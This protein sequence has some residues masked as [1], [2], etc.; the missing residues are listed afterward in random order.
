MTYRI[1]NPN[2]EVRTGLT[3]EDVSNFKRSLQRRG[4]DPKTSGY[5]LE[6]EPA[7]AP[8]GTSYEERR[9]Y[10]KD[11]SPMLAEMFPN[12]AEQ[13]MM[14]NRD[15]NLGT[16]KAGISDAL[17]YPGRFVMAVGNSKDTND[18]EGFNLGRRAEDAGGTGF[19]K[20]VRN[21]MFAGGMALAPA[22]GASAA[23]GSLVP[24]IAK[25]AAVGAAFGGADASLNGR[26]PG[27]ADYGVGAAI[28]GA[29]EPVAT[30]AAKAAALVRRFGSNLERA[31]ASALR[32]G[33]T[34]RLLTDAEFREFMADP[35][36][37]AVFDETIKAVE[38]WKNVN[39]LVT[40]KG[41]TLTPLKE[42]ARREAA[43]T[44]EGEQSLRQGASE[45]IDKDLPVTER[46]IQ[47]R[48]NVANDNNTEPYTLK[49]IYKPGKHD[50]TDQAYQRDFPEARLFESKPRNTK[51]PYYQSN[52]E[53]NIEK[54]ADKYDNIDNAV[55]SMKVDPAKKEMT[56]QE[57]AIIAD[58]EKELS[59]DNSVLKGYN[60]KTKE[61]DLNTVLSANKFLG[62]RVPF[63][64]DFYD[65]RLLPFIEENNFAGVSQ[66]F[67]D[68]VGSMVG[69]ANF[70]GRDTM[71]NLR[72]A[73]SGKERAV[74]ER[75]FAYA[76]D[77][78]RAVKK[79]TRDAFDKF[80]DTLSDYADDSVA[81]LRTNSSG[82]DYL[83]DS[84]KVKK[85]A[86][87]Y[88]KK[89][90]DAL[91]YNT[92]ISPDTIIGLYGDATLHN[93]KVVQDAV[94][95]LMRDLKVSNDV[96]RK[97][98]TVGRKYTMLKKARIKLDKNA[99]DDSNPFKGTI[100]AP[101]Y[102][103]EGVN[104]GNIVGYKLGRLMDR[105]DASRV[106]V[107]FNLGDIGRLGAYRL[108]MDRK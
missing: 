51:D 31:V 88:L 83:V 86:F 44:L 92:A 40:D 103:Q 27:I 101:I 81:S 100:A 23:T 74:L 87:T 45:G 24:N 66:K 5:V 62:D 77:G 39:P 96:I 102:P 57:Q 78:N 60:P 65:K 79:G 107:P 76:K 54:F 93:D 13:Y 80:A 37:R 25:G 90:Q 49:T 67:K 14:G 94:I 6:M 99:K 59:A 56:P 33:N 69:T 98:E 15:F 71:N 82:D 11:T 22:M 30:V 35:N 91:E 36:N 3:E 41:K 29:F 1:T 95:Q 85:Y 70:Y 19:G 16:V 48:A 21:P 61:Y 89:V 18:K 46:D 63:N 52:V 53:Y 28:G 32:L 4:L 20:T 2:G 105:A 50:I 97:F 55:Y 8:K 47:R 7:A 58:L 104:S 42:N 64:Q 43:A 10:F 12:L 17:S 73:F 38:N 9:E 84:D 34:D 75:A 72:E 68:E 108:N 26:E 106:D